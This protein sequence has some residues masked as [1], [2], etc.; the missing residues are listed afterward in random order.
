MHARLSRW[1]L[2][3]AA[4][5]ALLVRATA[6]QAPAPPPVTIGGLVYTQ[7]L[8]QLKDTANHINN[9]DITRA[10]VNVIGKFSGGIGT[11]VTA[12]IY[13]NADGSLGYRL[14]YAF[15]TYTPKGSPLTYKMGQIHTPWLDW[16]EALWDYRMQGQMALERGFIT[17]AGALQGY[18]SS[19]D[20]GAGVDGKLGPDKVNFQVGVF[21]G[22]NYNKAPG[23]K[24][25]DLMGRVSVRVVNTD[26][27]SRVGGLRV[28]AYG[29]YGKPTGGGERQR[30]VGMVSYRSKHVTL[31]GEAA[32][33]RDTV[34]APRQTPIN[35]HIYSAF[36]VFKFPKSKAALLAR[37]DL[38]NPQAGNGT[39]QQTRFIVGASYQL[40]PNWRLLADADLVSFQGTPT[41]AQEAVRAQALFQTQFT[42]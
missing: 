23:D 28:T 10:Y 26:D 22:E 38:E 11:R 39:D 7:Y 27:S 14:K 12:D 36:G 42:F 9:F 37:V 35:G 21:N 13:R 5:S 2:A 33:A 6:A 40:S 34:T 31:A 29:Q 30:W 32:I 41:A 18:L 20:F 15:A 8:Y 4:L 24:H 25:K 1:L 19:S 16:E 3:A 17:P